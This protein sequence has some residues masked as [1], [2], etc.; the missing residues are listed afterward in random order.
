MSSIAQKLLEG[1]LQNI[2]ENADTLLGELRS[3]RV[4]FSADNDA[5]K[6]IVEGLADASFKIDKYRIHCMDAY[7]APD[8]NQDTDPGPSQE[9]RS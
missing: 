2:Y 5:C 9:Q 1:W 7:S 3:D 4:H 8:H 6:E